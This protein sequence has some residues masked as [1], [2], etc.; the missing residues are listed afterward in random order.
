MRFMKRLSEVFTPP[1]HRLSSS[2]TVEA[3]PRGTPR[4]T[5]PP[6]MTEEDVSAQL[7]TLVR[8][9][10]D[11]ESSDERTRARARTQ[12]TEMARHLGTYAMAAKIRMVLETV[13]RDPQ[14][15][16]RYDFQRIHVLLGEF[17]FQHLFNEIAA[18]EGGE[19]QLG[20]NIF[21]TYCGDLIDA[22]C[23]GRGPHAALEMGIHITERCLLNAV[24][25]RE[26][27][28][29]YLHLAEASTRCTRDQLEHALRRPHRHQTP[30][31]MRR[32]G[33]S[34]DTVG[35]VNQGSQCVEYARELYA[36]VSRIREEFGALALAPAL[37]RA[38][39]RMLASSESP[40]AASAGLSQ[41][42]G[43]HLQY[44]QA[45][46][47][48]ARN[49]EYL[50]LVS[51]LEERGARTL[52]ARMRIESESPELLARSRA[53]YE[54]AAHHLE[55]HGDRENAI[56]LAPLSAQRYTKALELCAMAANDTQT[57]ALQEK[58]AAVGR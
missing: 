10:I 56:G 23:T 34:A 53:A 47:A 26:R 24:D 12:L 36:R 20:P 39:L 7:R 38:E 52:V 51:H 33:S 44:I 25:S 46:L 58:L 43:N 21:S 18:M 35:F 48:V 32:S 45:A 31:P 1:P 4:P 29:I 11:V 17:V 40:P 6:G 37:S 19:R 30:T 22:L 3:P 54:S 28:D 13:A 9:L 42:L 14:K 16:A 15:A 2:A 55:A 27:R 5:P 50:P 8:S 41:R 49:S 57:A